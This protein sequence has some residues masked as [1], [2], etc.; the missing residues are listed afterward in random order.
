M[1]DR[2][3]QLRDRG[4]FRKVDYPELGEYRAPSGAHF[5]LSK[6]SRDARRA[7]ILGEHNEYVFKG[8]LGLPD[9]EYYRL[10]RERVIA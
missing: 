2:D 5:Q 9:D 10:V 4:F 1:L 8:L 3:P 6:Y 7:P